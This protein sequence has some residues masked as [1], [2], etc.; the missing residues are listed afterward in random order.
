MT[1]SPLFMGE[2]WLLVA[3]ACDTP[4]GISPVMAAGYQAPGQTRVT[5]VRAGRGARGGPGGSGRVSHRQGAGRT[6]PG[7]SAPGSR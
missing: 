5:S 7:V 3:T 1:L 6:F 2:S 4:S